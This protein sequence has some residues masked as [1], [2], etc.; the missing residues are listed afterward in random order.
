MNNLEQQLKQLK[1]LKPDQEFLQ[2]SRQEILN[3][4]KPP[5]SI[6]LLKNSLN[7][8][9]AVGLAALLMFVVTD[10]LNKSAQPSSLVE[11]KPDFSIKL[12]EAR[13]FKEIAPDVYVVVLN[14][15]PENTERT[16]E[17]LTK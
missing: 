14:D 9:V 5:R 1:H 10:G 8:A 3:T 7:F 16:I 6:F 13:Y 4:S 12:E 2:Y 11:N 15:A 17:E